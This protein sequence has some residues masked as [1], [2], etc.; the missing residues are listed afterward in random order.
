MKVPLARISTAGPARAISP[1]KVALVLAAA[2][3][4]SLRVKSV[5]LTGSRQIVRAMCE[6]ITQIYELTGG[7]QLRGTC[8]QEM[9]L[10]KQSRGR[11]VLA[12]I[13]RAD[14]YN[15]SAADVGKMYATG[16]KRLIR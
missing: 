10:M 3:G 16:L 7:V 12:W 1:T 13:M 8:A 9:G 5:N 6:T 15:F 4:A 2:V 14:R 11:S